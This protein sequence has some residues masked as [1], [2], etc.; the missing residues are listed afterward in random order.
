MLKRYYITLGAT[1]TAGG[2]VTSASAMASMD[3]ARIALE[4]D[5]VAC[6]ACNSEG[7]IQPD[8]A[9]LID[10]LIDDFGGR[11]FAL[12]DDLCICGCSPPPRLVSSQ[13]QRG[14]HIDGG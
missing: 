3:G 4:G 12:S 6:P 10:L 13:T 14:Q 7:V 2:T 5:K 1:T 9:R 11:L 8:G